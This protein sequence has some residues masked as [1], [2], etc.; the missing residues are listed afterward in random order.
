MAP[1]QPSD[2][3]NAAPGEAS[4]NGSE[5][6]VTHRGQEPNTPLEQRNPVL[7]GLVWGVSPQH[8]DTLSP[9]PLPTAHLSQ[10]EEGLDDVPLHLQLEVDEL[11]RQPVLRLPAQPQ[12]L[13]ARAAAALGTT[14]DRQPS[15]TQCG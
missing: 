8:G 5:R 9:G 13:P 14:G 7:P 10:H 6:K 3:A 4:V 2:G 15:H 1:Q 12:H 11:L